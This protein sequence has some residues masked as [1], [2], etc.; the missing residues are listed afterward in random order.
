MSGA[1]LTSFEW[2]G[3][4]ALL[5]AAGACGWFARGWTDP[6]ELIV[7]PTVEDCAPDPA[8]A[9]DAPPDG[10]A[11]QQSCLQLANILTGANVTFDKPNA[12]V[13]E[14]CLAFN[15]DWSGPAACDALAPASTVMPPEE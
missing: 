3:L 6:G 2:L 5:I 13:Y 10:S 1:S 15:G 9:I 8:H 14:V 4:A 11:G 7:S 12:T